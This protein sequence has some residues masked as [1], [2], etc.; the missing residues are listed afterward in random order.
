MAVNLPRFQQIAAL[1]D[2]DGR[3]S[4]A[5]HIWWDTFAKRLEDTLNDQADQLAAIQ[6]LQTEMAARV[7]EI[8]ALQSAME[9]RI[10]EIEAAQATADAAKTNNAISASWVSGLTLSASDAGTDASIVISNHTRYYDDETS[11][12][13]I[14]TTLTGLAYTTQYHIYY[15]DVTRSDTTPSYQT[16]TD[17]TVAAPNRANGRHYVGSVTTPAAG[18]AATDGGGSE[19]PGWKGTGT[20]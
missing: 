3:P 6:T 20:L 12:A 18:G 1:V 15:D 17:A 7:T 10:T 9:D 2:S 5:F 4:S 19:P 16:T 11:L 13:V 14:G 8:E